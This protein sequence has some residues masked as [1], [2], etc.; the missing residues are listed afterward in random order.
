MSKIAMTTMKIAR[1]IER[2][3]FNTDL[4]RDLGLV[5]KCLSR[6]AILRSSYS[7]PRR[8]TSDRRWVLELNQARSVA[9]V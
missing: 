7:Q 2:N 5:L 4:L 3:S 6:L 1:Q 9:I 8:T